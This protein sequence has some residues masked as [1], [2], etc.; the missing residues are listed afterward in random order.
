MLSFL[1]G[2]RWWMLWYLFMWFWLLPAAGVFYYFTW[3]VPGAGPQGGEAAFALM[4]FI[5]TGLLL[6]FLANAVLWGFATPHGFA[7]RWLLM[8]MVGLIGWGVMLTLVL[9]GADAV[10]KIGGEA[11]ERQIANVAMFAIYVIAILINCWMLQRFRD[12]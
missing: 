8:P 1:F 2:R 3:F 4:L 5:W 12:A 11:S 7:Y 10:G 9:V 6:V